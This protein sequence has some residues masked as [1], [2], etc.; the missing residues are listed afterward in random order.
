VKHLV[1]LARAVSPDLAKAFQREGAPRLGHK[2]LKR[3]RRIIGGKLRYVYWYRTAEEAS[4]GGQAAQEQRVIAGRNVEVVHLP[5]SEVAKEHP[6]L[7]KQAMEVV[8]ATIKAIKDWLGIGKAVVKKTAI[9]EK[10]HDLPYIAAEKTGTKER[11]L[12]PASRIADAVKRLPDEVKEL[13]EKKK[14]VSEFRMQDPSDMDPVLL[15]NF[16][17]P[18][19]VGGYFDPKTHH[20]VI[21]GGMGVYREPE[22]TP[23][24]MG[25]FTLLEDVVAHETGHAVHHS[26]IDHFKAAAEEW[27]TLSADNSEPRITPYAGKN[28]YED[29]AETFG[30][31]VNYPKQLAQKCPKRYEFLR[32]HVLKATLPPIDEILKAPDADLAWW[33]KTPTTS[34]TRLLNYLKMVDP[35]QPFA[36]HHS[37]KDQFYAV[38]KDGKT[39][40]VRIGPPDPVS[41]DTWTKLASPTDEETGLPTRDEKLGP[42]FKAFIKEFYD[43]TGK[44]LTDKQ[45]YFYLGQFDEDTVAHARLG[46]EKPEDYLTYIA[47]RERKA[48]T[49]KDPVTGK[50]KK[51]DDTHRLSYK[52]Y[53]ALGYSAERG[54]TREKERK[55]AQAALAAGKDPHRAG[56]DWA[57]V[58]ITRDEFVQKS[59][60]FAFGELRYAR[61][62]SERVWPRKEGGKDVLVYDPSLK[63]TVRQVTSKIYEQE[64]PDGTI[65]QVVVATASPFQIGEKII[66]PVEVEIT[67]EA[68]LKHRVREWREDTVTGTA[69]P[70]KLARKYKTTAK[71]LLEKNGVYA[72]GQ[73]IDPVLA[74]L[75]NPN[76]VPIESEADLQHIMREAAKARMTSADPVTGLPMQHGIRRWF[77]V[78]MRPS[79]PATEQY[80]S[81]I[82]HLQLEYDG[83]GP[84]KVVG[85]YW[86]RKLGK[87]EIRIDEL[88]TRR[89]EIKAGSIRLRS[90]KKVAVAPGALVWALDQKTKRRV[91]A[92]VRK[93]R[94]D[95]SAEVENVKGQGAGITQGAYI[96]P[97][98][99]AT[100]DTAVPGQ[101][102][103]QRRFVDPLTDDVLLYMDDVPVG[104]NEFDPRGTIKI[105]LPKSGRIGAEEIK[106]MPG[107]AL[108]MGVGVGLEQDVVLEA[109]QEIA[110]L[111]EYLGG[112]MMDSRV[113]AQLKQL[114]EH[115]RMLVEALQDD[116]ISPEDLQDAH[117]NVN[118]DGPLRALVPGDKGI[119][120]IPFRVDALQKLARMGGVQYFAHSMGTGKTPL[121]IAAASLFR[122]LKDPATGKLHS[123]AVRKR[124]IFVGPPNTV[125][126][127][128]QEQKKFTT[129]RA[130]LLGTSSLAGALAIPDLSGHVPYKAGE[131]QEAYRKRAIEAWKKLI[132]K[133]PKYWNPFTDTSKNVVINH[134]YFREHAKE[135]VLLDQF[136]GLVLDEAQ[137]VAR[138]NILSAEIEKWMQKMNLRVLMSGTPLTNTLDAIPRIMRILTGGAMDLGSD[139][140][141]ANRYLVE[142]AIMKA[143]GKKDGPKTDLNP[144]TVGELMMKLQ[145]YLHVA[146]PSD[147]VGKT[148]PAVLLDE[149]N[150]AHMTGQQARLYRLSQAALTPE[151]QE[152]L[153]ASGALGLD[154]EKMLSAKGRKK[155]AVGRSYGNS[156]G[157][158]PPD[159]REF[160]IYETT[161]ITKDKKT[162][163]LKVLEVKRQFT[164]PTLDVIKAKRPAGWGGRWPTREEYEHDPNYFLVLEMLAPYLFNKDYRVLAGKAIDKATLDKIEAGWELPTGDV[165]GKEG[166]KVRNPEYGPEGAIAR[167]RLDDKT[168]EVTPVEEV[169]FGPDGK[170]QITIPI[171]MKFIRDPN[172]KA[173]AKY[174]VQDDWNER[175]SFTDTGEAGDTSKDRAERE[176]EE[177]EEEEKSS[178]EEQK[179][180][181]EDFEF[182]PEK[183]AEEKKKKIVVAGRGKQGPKPGHE[184]FDIQTSPKRRRERF[185]FDHTMTH[186]NA[187]CDE[188]EKR[189]K[190]LLDPVHGGGDGVQM[191]IFGN[192]VGSAVRT[193]ESKLR[194]MG[195]M[196]VNEALGHADIS[197]DFDKK[198]A[199]KTRKFF[200][201]YMGAGATQGN[202]DLN[203]EI[204]RRQLDMFGKDTGLSM[205]VARALH[206][207]LG[208]IPAA[209][210]ISEGWS[211][212]QRKKIAQNFV[213]ETMTDKK[214]RRVGLE[215]PLRVGSFD[216]KGKIV[217]RY[218]YETEM[219]PADRK[220]FK[221]LEQARIAAATEKEGD[222]LLAQMKAVLK[223]YWVDRLPLSDR[224][225]RIMNNCDFMI[226]SDAAQTGL[227][228]SGVTQLFMYDSLFSSMAEW[229]RIAR[230]TR[231][232]PPAVRGPAKKMIEK[233]GA[234]IEKIEKENGF[235]EYEGID[236]AMRIVKEGIQSAL[237]S[238]ERS[239]INTMPGGAP[240]QILEAWFAKRAMDKIAKYR[241]EVAARLKVHGRVPNKLKPE[242]PENFVRPE[243]ITDADVMN[244][245]L[246][247]RLTLFDREILKSRRYLV[248]VQR[249]TVSADMPVYET[250]VDKDPTTGKKKKIKRPTGAFAV[251]SPVM[252]ERSQ[253][254]RGRVK[255]VA[256][257]RLL[258]A[259]QTAQPVKTNYDFVDVRSSSFAK[260][261][262]LPKEMKEAETEKSMAR[263]FVRPQTEVPSWLA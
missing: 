262:L 226:A 147:V 21:N 121:S 129:E 152:A 125:E 161:Q 45:A 113:Q 221:E 208:E 11:G 94:P 87:T 229:Q 48:A 51:F 66:A 13:L 85:D 228:W 20:V 126:N 213:S 169:F 203:S 64:N 263:F 107:V 177:D 245:I 123:R 81:S 218:V 151:E 110:R 160:L 109:P 182:D 1:P 133:N 248:S 199:D 28:I 170:E 201:S 225:M 139:E 179:E 193:S 102:D 65:A 91:H 59:G 232:L 144:A 190:A 238:A 63:K 60:T 222:E 4:R 98:V 136:D 131:S 54:H 117:G 128:M 29:F 82:V 31:A 168:G 116:V 167:G 119:Q 2:Y 186:G 251:E 15:S 246:E 162:N 200:V 171:G 112:F 35:A 163:K 236:S 150:P 196:D 176:K 157:Y 189:I 122:N 202:R 92:I 76:D 89:D 78:Q 143:A 172:Q 165:W 181:D 227:N 108:R 14:G 158:K 187:K 149:N 154:E 204:F 250:I 124:C 9:F 194:L 30:C 7:A 180:T 24:Y 137:V 16:M 192:R 259:V 258:N 105:R 145:P 260:L 67:D 174:Y 237:T 46:G 8:E 210:E 77:S 235:K 115:E 99:E 70:I 198:K 141:F 79:G 97:R 106:R 111:R 220:R 43:E 72:R 26:L 261:S 244:E 104:S 159:D 17:N 166:G 252:A 184:E 234:Y 230:A 164:L 156:P 95:G 68:G 39:V 231:L 47:E 40:Y 212:G 120:M 103:V 101:P 10:T 56:Y 93:L 224:Q 216:V 257:E 191:V 175:G 90:P 75:V 58:E 18:N 242:S 44:P 153:A 38:H 3:E 22:G 71:E 140:E 61:E 62:K 19:E 183:E 241:E 114:G 118:P 173:A 52:M 195:Y 254:A 223:P 138:E 130:V 34:A 55:R 239:L 243:A 100:F 148:M 134:A 80:S 185:M 209:G 33:D 207:E 84:P 57:P 49:E 132:E 205:F 255:Q 256:F 86:A 5:A 217:Q 233:I 197:T 42:R 50:K 6:H 188:M 249:L 32:K 219:K 206:G 36:A 73:I 142:S 127:W 215:M 214:G 53:E 74:S 240:D 41:E 253:L 247:T 12:A 37:D 88:L 178:A 23:R 211:R 27:A 135:L 69:D 25:S 96:V 83:L 146:L 155:T